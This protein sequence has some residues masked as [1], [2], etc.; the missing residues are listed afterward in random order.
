[1]LGLF[2]GIAALVAGTV[3]LAR[4]RRLWPLVLAPV[5]TAFAVIL[6]LGAVGV[7]AALGL[8]HQL[9]GRGA[10]AELLGVL[11]GL[12]AVLLA[13]LVGVTL[14]Q[15]LSGWAL[16][17]IV[18]AQD[19]ALGSAPSEVHRG[20]LSAWAAPLLALAI[21]G[22][23]VVLL[24][25]VGWTFPPAAPVTVPAKA[26]VAALLLAWDLL[27]Y[28]LALR[29][30]RLRSRLSWCGRHLGEVIGFGLAAMIFFSVPGLGLLALPCGVAGATRLTR[31]P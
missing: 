27:D 3:W 14:A 6:A 22:P 29:G 16:D 8:A 20:M 9:L 4:T 13:I 7:R 11:F 26:L 2:R 23:L 10:G 25:V 30:V 18:R 24:T 21:G 1:M 28:P 17:A 19:K 12:G 31:A 15:P 5:V